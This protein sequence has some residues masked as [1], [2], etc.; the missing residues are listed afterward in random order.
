M[1]NHSPAKLAISI[2]SFAKR[3]LRD[4]ASAAERGG[5]FKEVNGRKY[6][7]ETDQVG[8]ESTKQC[9]GEHYNGKKKLFCPPLV[10]LNRSSEVLS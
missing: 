10:V 3:F 2:S 1:S 6:L 8:L 7:I 5:R 4:V 9:V